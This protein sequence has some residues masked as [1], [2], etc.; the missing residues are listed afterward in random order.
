MKKN[1]IENCLEK[2]QLMMKNAADECG[3]DVNDIALVAVSKTRTPEEI[4]TAIPVVNDGNTINN[5]HPIRPSK[6]NS[7]V[8]I[9]LHHLS[10]LI[11]R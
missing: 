1:S 9:I 3:R 11:N 4:N 7:M 10:D 6:S 8:I 2:V 5:K